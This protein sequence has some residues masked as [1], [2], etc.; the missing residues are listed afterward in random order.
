MQSVRASRYCTCLLP[1]VLSIKVFGAANEMFL[2]VVLCAFALKEAVALVLQEEERV[3][4]LSD[5]FAFYLP[6]T[7]E[8]AEQGDLLTDSGTLVRGDRGGV[9]K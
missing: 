9:R 8:A 1:F 2:V 4:L 7:G 5:H 3:S 6:P